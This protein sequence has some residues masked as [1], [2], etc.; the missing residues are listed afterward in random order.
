MALLQGCSA[1]EKFCVIP[2]KILDTSSAAVAGTLSSPV[3]ATLVPS[4][5]SSFQ[6]IIPLVFPQGKCPTPAT[7]ESALKTAYLATPKG[8]KGLTVGP[9]TAAVKMG[10]TRVAAVTVKDLKGTF[11]SKVGPE[12][13]TEP[14]ITAIK[15]VATT[16]D[17][18]IKIRP[19]DLAG[20]TLKVDGSSCA[21]SAAGAKITF[22][23]PNLKVADR[24]QVPSGAG[25]LQVR[26]VL[27]AIGSL[28]NGQLVRVSDLPKPL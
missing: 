22:E 16:S 12:G 27:K 2:C 3:A 13:I 23:C 7:L 4:A 9:T 17:S 11:S 25:D 10:Q 24:F 1:E 14:I 20:Q 21:I 6:G 26:G 5:K 8:W 15:G 18:P 28:A 19:I